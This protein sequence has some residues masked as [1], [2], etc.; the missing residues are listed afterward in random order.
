MLVAV[1]RVT[2]DLEEALA[3]FGAYAFVLATEGT[4]A[5]P[6]LARVSQMHVQPWREANK[7]S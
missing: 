2:E 1:Q 4:K 7:C 5:S 6:W 3:L